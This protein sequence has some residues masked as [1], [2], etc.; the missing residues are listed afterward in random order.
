M[1][2]NEEYW[3]SVENRIQ[4]QERFILTDDERQKIQEQERKAYETNIDSIR[5]IIVDFQH[6]LIERSFDTNLK[7]DSSGF[8]FRYS[9]VGYF[10]PAGFKAQ[11]HIDGPLVLARLKPAGSASNYVVDNKLINNCEIGS[12]YDPIKFRLFL[13]QNLDNFLDP[14][15]L[16]STKERRVMLETLQ[17]SHSDR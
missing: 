10:G 12:G 17:A 7:L 14:T 4:Q 2:M 16:I 13:R 9:K 15:N 3:K 11:L 6:K 8:M 1:T 5:T